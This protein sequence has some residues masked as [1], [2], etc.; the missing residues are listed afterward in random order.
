[1][2]PID[3]L[4]INDLHRDDDINSDEAIRRYYIPKFN[5]V[6]FQIREAKKSSK[7]NIVYKV[8]QI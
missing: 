2:E 8:R 7:T 1:M 4:H 3:D 5:D 6:C